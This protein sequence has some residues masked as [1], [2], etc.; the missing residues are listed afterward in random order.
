MG[1]Y[2]VLVATTHAETYVLENLET[3]KKI[4]VKRISPTI[5]E[6]GQQKKAAITKVLPVNFKLSKF[7]CPNDQYMFKCEDRRL[8]YNLS[9]VLEPFTKDSELGKDSIVELST[10]E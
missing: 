6:D 5:F 7:R 10:W 2:Y 1:Y 3:S 8:L 9:D 4:S